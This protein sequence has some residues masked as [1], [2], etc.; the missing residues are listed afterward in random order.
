MHRFDEQSEQLWHAAIEMARRR[1]I[2]PQ[3]VRRPRTR[4]ELTPLLVDTITPSGIGSD[5]AL[6]LFQEVV[7]EFSITGDH[8]RFFSFIGHAPTEAAV[9]GDILLSAHP[10]YGG[11]WLEGAGAIQAENVVLTWL[12]KLAGLPPEAGG[13]FV[14]GGTVGNLSA[15]H[16]ARQSARSSRGDPIGKRWALVTSS[17]AH[18]S[19]RSAASVL[20][21]DVLTVT[22]GP[23]EKLTGEAIAH[24]L[25]Y[26]GERVFAVVAAAGSTNLGTIDDLISI[27]RVCREAGVWLHVDG[28]YG[29]A[30]LVSPDARAKFAGIELCDSFIVDPHK[31]LF[32]TY[33][34]CGLIYRD[35]P[36]ARRAHTQSAAYLDAL[37]GDD[38]WH[39]AN[40]AIH[41]SRRA[42]GVP[43]WFSLAVNGERAYA[44]A[45]DATLET[46]R[47]AA[48]AV[49]ER[50]WLTLLAEP[51]LS[52]VAFQRIG[53][54]WQNC[55]DWAER[56]LQEG[57][58]FVVP[59]TVAG[60]PALRLAIQ[61]P[62]ATIDD[63]IAVLES[64]A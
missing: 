61:H 51:E 44:A 35:P 56:L 15:L 23:G 8:R 25:G 33:D 30:A 12:A 47:L 22:V 54:S 26:E 1:R 5:E 6:R 40:Y 2:E 20:D 49:K 32:S 3:P 29:L 42:R 11:D 16:V 37:D 45:I 13:C 62:N 52:V 48:S 59:T 24:L 36:I 27:G 60:E 64:L 63:V 41:L 28:S 4:E 46:T 7:A 21:V 57:V 9:I 55:I 18:S 17:E 43:V 53:W 19:V 31:W 39:P 34:C 58:A 14:S 50:A 38:Q 10:L